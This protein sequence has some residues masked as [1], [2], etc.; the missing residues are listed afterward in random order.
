MPMIDHA[1][2]ACAAR[3][4]GCHA[5]AAEIEAKGL[6]AEGVVRL[7]KLS[8]RR[9]RGQIA[10]VVLLAGAIARHAVDRDRWQDRGERAL[11]LSL[12]PRER[13]A[14]ADRRATQLVRSHWGEIT[15]NGRPSKG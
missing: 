3:A 10:A 6:D 15:K 14:E 5:V 9:D 13:F 8:A 7:L 4:C 12:I 1:A 2:M 11:V